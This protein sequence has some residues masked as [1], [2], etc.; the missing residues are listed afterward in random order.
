MSSRNVEREIVSAA[1]ISDPE[2]RRRRLE[3]FRQEVDEQVRYVE[4]QLKD[5]EFGNIVFGKFCS[6][7][8]E[9]PGVS[10]VFGLASALYNAF[11]QSPQVSQ[12]SPLVYAAYAQVELLR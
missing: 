4:A 3:L 2:L 10:F 9:I 1:A 11:Q 12:P 7:M 5:N 6:V 8:A